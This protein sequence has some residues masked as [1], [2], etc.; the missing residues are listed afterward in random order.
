MCRSALKEGVFTIA[1][2]KMQIGY[3]C[4]LQMLQV[5]QEV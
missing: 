3:D 2:G 4:A 1:T 5:D